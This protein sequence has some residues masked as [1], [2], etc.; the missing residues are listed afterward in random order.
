MFRILS[1]KSIACIRIAANSIIFL[2]G[3]HEQVQNENSAAIDA[4]KRTIV[5]I[6]QNLLNL[7]LYKILLKQ[8]FRSFFNTDATYR[9]SN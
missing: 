5:S 3:R 2:W 7:S 6:E 4:K 9:C 8:V 1:I